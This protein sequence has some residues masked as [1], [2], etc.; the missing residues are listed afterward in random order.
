MKGFYIVCIA[1]VIVCMPLI[2]RP[3][4]NAS[5]S[6]LLNTTRTRT[7]AFAVTTGTT[8][9]T[10]AGFALF[11][12]SPAPN[13][14]QNNKMGVDKSDSEWQAQLSPEQVSY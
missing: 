7:R 11:S 8:S 12:S 5:R 1:I 14:N 9:T 2:Y 13:Q 10:A 3:L 6:L 4:V